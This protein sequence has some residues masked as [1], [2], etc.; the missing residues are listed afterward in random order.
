M[1]EGWGSHFVGWRGGRRRREGAGCRGRFRSNTKWSRGVVLVLQPH[2]GHGR[3]RFHAPKSLRSP[4]WGLSKWLWGRSWG[5]C[6]VIGLSV[7]RSEFELLGPGSGRGLVSH[8]WRG[9]EGEVGLGSSG[10]RTCRLGGRRR[11]S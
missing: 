8:L 1:I 7:C 10:G 2:R 4:D 9:E 3:P 6:S 5:G 11:R